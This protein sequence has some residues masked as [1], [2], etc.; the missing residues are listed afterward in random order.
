[1]GLGLVFIIR[2]K[3]LP[4]PTA[5]AK[6]LFVDWATYVEFL[7]FGYVGVKKFPGPPAR[8][9]VFLTD[10][11]GRGISC[12]FSEICLKIDQ[13]LRLKITILDVVMKK[14]HQGLRRGLKSCLYV[15]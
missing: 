6:S 4:G 3:N 10:S 11:P 9:K 1:M 8:A 14:N 12:L 2:E 5:G 13:G 15:N 7:F